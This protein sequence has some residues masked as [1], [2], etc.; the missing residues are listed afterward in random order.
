MNQSQSYDRINWFAKLVFGYFFVLLLYRIHSHSMLWYTFGQPLKCP[1]TDYTFW[2]SHL[3]G[4]PNYIIQY[5]WLC[6]FID[7]AIIA[8]NLI[9]FFRNEKRYLYC[10]ALVLLFFIQRITVESYSCSHT[11]SISCLFIGLLPFC[12]KKKNDIEL[13]IEFGRYFLIYIF[14]ISAWNKLMNGALTDAES[15]SN[16]LISQHLDLATLHPKHI[17][18][19]IA[20]FLIQ[21]PILANLSFKLLFIIQSSF[22]IGIFSKRFDRILFVLLVL[23]AISSYFIMRI[24]NFDIV[25]LGLTL[26]YFP[27]GKKSG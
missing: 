26:L 9:C 5:K 13:L 23:F 18:Y 24:Y 19:K 11:K 17:S 7:V 4:F 6:L 12:F 15:F 14:L 1:G 2:I 22:L 25:L 3:L 21:Y 8:L 27:V 16:T 20:I 10:L